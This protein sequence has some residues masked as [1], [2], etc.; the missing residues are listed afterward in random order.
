MYIHDIYNLLLIIYYIICY[1]IE[2]TFLTLLNN[3]YERKLRTLEQLCNFNKSL[4]VGNY[5]TFHIFL[6]FLWNLPFL[7]FTI[8]EI[9]KILLETLYKGRKFS[10]V[11]HIRN[12]GRVHKSSFQHFRKEVLHLHRLL[13]GGHKYHQ[14]IPKLGNCAHAIFMLYAW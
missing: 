8:F 9:A 1:R 2:F 3:I 7:P 6:I 13:P 10:N 14:Q 12:V 11:S 4:R 5:I